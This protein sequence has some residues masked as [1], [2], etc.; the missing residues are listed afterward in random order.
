MNSVAMTFRLDNKMIIRL[1][2]LARITHRSKSF[3]TAEAI[4]E[5]LE[6]QE[7]QLKEIKQGIVEANNAQLIDHS[8]VIKH[9]ERKQACAFDE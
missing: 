3:L 6:V 5:Y 1:K 8:K 2:R 9:W 7:W 4:S